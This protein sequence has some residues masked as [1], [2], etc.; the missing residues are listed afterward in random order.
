MIHACRRT[1][2]EKIMNYGNDN[3]LRSTLIYLEDFTAAAAA[4]EATTAEAVA[5]K[6]TTKLLKL[7][8]VKRTSLEIKVS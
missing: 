7:I 5:R 8:S 6:T 1:R 4:E 2:D 3:H